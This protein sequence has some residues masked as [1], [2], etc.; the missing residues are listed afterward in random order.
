MMK[1]KGRGAARRSGQQIFRNAQYAPSL[2]NPNIE[3]TPLCKV[4]VTLPGVRGASGVRGAGG[5]DEQEGIRPAPGLAG[6]SVW[7]SACRG[8]LRVTQSEAA[9]GLS[10]RTAIM[11][12]KRTGCE[13]RPKWMSMICLKINPARR[14]EPGQLKVL[15]HFSVSRAICSRNCSFSASRSLTLRIG[16]AAAWVNR[17]ASCVPIGEPIPVHGSGPGRAR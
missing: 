11:T 6:R 1:V 4:D 5:V 8:R 3:M 13:T 2:C 10:G 7:P 14:R 15:C 12:A 16:F 17:S 9:P